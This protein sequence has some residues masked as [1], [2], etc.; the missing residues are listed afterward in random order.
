MQPV[1]KLVWPVV[2]AIAIAGGSYFGSLGLTHSVAAADSPAA[3]AKPTP[4]PHTETVAPAKELSL[5]FRN[6]HHVLENA[7]VNIQIVKKEAAEGGQGRMRMQLPPGFQLPQ[8]FPGFGQGDDQNAP[9]EEVRGTG[10]GVIVSPDGYI[11]TNNHV[12]EDATDIEVRLNDG[13]NLKA[14]VIGT[15]PKTDLAVVRIAADHLTYAKFGDSDATEVGDIVVAFGSPLGFEQ[16]MTQGIISAKG[17]QIGIIGSHNPSLQGLSYEDFLQTDAAI[18]PG[19]SG[20]PLVNLDG[21]VI[22]INAA[23]AS[24]TGYYNGIGFSIPSNEAR[25]I[26]DSLIKNGKVVRGFLNVGIE[27]INNPAEK[28]KGLADSIVK[29]GFKGTGA[30]VTEIDPDGPAGKGGVQSGDVITALN[31]KTVATV[32][33]LRNQIARTAPGT[34]VTLSIYREGKTVELTFPL[35]TQPATR[36]LAAAQ[37]SDQSEVAGNA[38]GIGQMRSVNEAEAHKYRLTPGHGV[39]VTDVDQNGAA[40]MGG[41]QAGDV[42]TQVN[43]VHV[44]TPEELNAELSKTKL[45]EGVRLHVRSVDGMDRLLYL[46]SSK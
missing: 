44:S 19:N 41:L 46:S 28:D 31:G 21:E 4:E 16:T 6:V 43:G 14:K 2:A 25:Y 15:D 34:S 7:V 30:L 23:I 35:G 39:M 17:R 24:N 29:S 40:A 8:G 32:N 3:T 18:N 12:V 33:Q 11:L 45:A 27:D 42:I 5:A 13:R 38:L 1:K 10:S 26:M 37:G 36:E 9:E 22:G 20:G